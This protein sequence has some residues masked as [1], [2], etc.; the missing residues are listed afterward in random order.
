MKKLFAGMLVV[1][2]VGLLSAFYAPQKKVIKVTKVKGVAFQMP[3]SVKTI[4]NHSCYECH[5]SKASGDEKDFMNFDE[6]STMEAPQLVAH[7]YNM[8]KMVKYGY[9]PPKK[10][11]RDHPDMALTEKQKQ[12]ILNWVK[13]ENEKLFSQK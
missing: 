2:M 11:V 1:T 7:L 8:G 4:V 10:I 6:L 13:A 5:N 3:D 12:I 9:M